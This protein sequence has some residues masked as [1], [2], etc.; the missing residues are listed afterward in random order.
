MN[1]FKANF[2]LFISFYEISAKYLDNKLHIY[3]VIFLRFALFFFCTTKKLDAFFPKLK[4]R[5]VIQ[6]V[7]K[8]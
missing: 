2:T 5:I 3:K 6:P 1:I 7:F 4:Q 8:N